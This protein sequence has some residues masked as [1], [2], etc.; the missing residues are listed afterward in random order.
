MIGVGKTTLT[1]KLAKHFNSHPFFEPVGENPVLPLYYQNSKRYGFLLQIFFL[2]KRFKM[3]KR[4]L[5][6][7][8][9]VL[10]RS[11]Y[12]DALF[13]KQNYLD[14]NISEPEYA[15]YRELLG[16]MITDL[17]SMNKQSPDLMVYAY[18]DFE[19]ILSRIKKRGRDYEQFDQDAKLKDYYY[20]LW[21]AYQTWYD[22]YDHSPKIKIDLQKYDLSDVKNLPI[23]LD[24]ID[25]AVQKF[26]V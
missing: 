19:T 23:I 17:D 20:Q 8:H 7:N 10:D 1:G 21:Q 24:Q 13:T 26:N 2:N 14:G 5:R 4:A 25:T 3:I 9:N 11:I 18:A 22:E 15:V 16:N 6:N 12:E